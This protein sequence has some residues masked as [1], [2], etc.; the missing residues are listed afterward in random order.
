MVFVKAL[1][2]NQAARQGAN[3]GGGAALLERILEQRF[4]EPEQEVLGGC[5]E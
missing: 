2:S 3:Q 4:K 1:K 5:G